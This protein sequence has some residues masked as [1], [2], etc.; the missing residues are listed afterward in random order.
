MRRLII[1]QI[2][3]IL[4]TASAIAVEWDFRTPPSAEWRE[5]VNSDWR[6]Y[7]DLELTL[8]LSE[9]DTNKYML[10]SFFFQTKQDQWFQN[11]TPLLLDGTVQRFR[12]RL[13]GLSPDWRC[14]NGRRPFDR[15]VLRWVRC[16]GVK[17]FSPEE[18]SGMITMNR[19]HF[20]PRSNATPYFY[21]IELPV[22]SSTGRLSRVRFRICG[23]DLNPFD[24]DQ[25][26]GVLISST[27]NGEQAIPVYY[28][29]EYITI[30]HP[31][32]GET[33]MQPLE[34]PF[35]E[36]NWLPVTT[37]EC[38]LAVSMM[39]LGKKYER[40]IGRVQVNDKTLTEQCE[41]GLVFPEGESFDA[42]GDDSVLL[43]YDSG[44]W[45][46]PP[47][48]VVNGKY[49]AVPLDWTGKWGHYFGLG[50]FDQMIAWKFEQALCCYTGKPMPILFFG[51]DELDNMG[52]FNWIDHP[53]NKA[54]GGN[55]DRP[56]D[57]FGDDLA[58]ALVLDRARYLW[59]RYGHYAGVSGL[60][61]LTKRSEQP[62]VEWIRHVALT[63]SDELPDV[64]IV[65]NNRDVADR[66]ESLALG[67]YNDWT[68]DERLSI[69]TDLQ[70]DA[71][72]KELLL[73]ARRTGTAA[74]T[75]KGIRHWQ[76]ANA[77][78][79]DIHSA[80]SPDYTVKVLCAIRTDP[81]SVFESELK[82]LR[83][84]EWTRVTFDLDKSNLWRCVGDGKRQMEQYDLLNIREVALRFFG[85]NGSDINLRIKDPI[86][87]WPYEID[88]AARPRFAISDIKSNAKNVHCYEKFEL[89]F[90]LN[91]MFRNPYDPNEID[92]MIEIKDPNGGIM[93]H[94]G[95][96]HEPWEIK[97][98]QD[99]EVADRSGLPGWRVRCAPKRI[100]RHSWT[101]LAV[102][103]LETASVSGEFTCI[104]PR[105]P[106]F[107]MVSKSDPRF[108]EF[109][110]GDYYYPI[111]HNIRSPSDMRPGIYQDDVLENA[112]WADRLGIMAYAKWFK[113]M[114][115]HGENFS[116]IWITPW[117]CGLEWNENHT[118]YYGLGYYN[119]ANAARLDTIL[120]LAEKENIYINLETMHH[121]ALS[122]H[123][124]SDWKHNP[125][126]KTTQ[127]NGLIRYA[128]DFIYDQQSQ[129]IHRM[130]LRYAVARWGYSRAIA[131]WGVMTE[132]EWVEPYYRSLGRLTGKNIPQVDWVPF[133]YSASEHKQPF[134]EWLSRTADYIKSTDSHEHLV[135]V[136]FSNPE[137]GTEV[138]GGANLDIVHNNTYTEFVSWWG[139]G[140]LAS[141]DG[142][143][144]V[145]L[146]FSDIYDRY[147]KDKPLMVG[148]WGGSPLKNDQMHLVAELHTGIWAMSM[149]RIAGIGGYWWWNLVD[150]KS[151]YSHFSA[152]ANFL[153]GEDRRGKHYKSAYAKIEFPLSATK[154]LKSERLGLVLYN[155]NTLF[156]YL[157]N[158]A[159][160]HRN[161]SIVATG[162]NDPS[163]P[164][165][166]V[167]G[168][169]IPEIMLNGA[170]TVEYWDTFAGKIIGSSK[171]SL[172]DTQRKIPIIS[173]RVDLAL[174]MKPAA[175]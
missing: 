9:G 149:T 157:C 44:G 118:G 16:W 64:R 110:N 26:S 47:D 101:V 148:E 111:G 112:S 7:E 117:W 72:T 15:D 123:I 165:S 63:L 155:R 121:G 28:R 13:D 109:S 20:S 17:I 43:E 29:Q 21:D 170:Y 74:I 145:M 133:D 45:R 154:D 11:R 144:D 104:A 119:Q 124:D 32:T 173:Y 23:L 25:V 49:W 65:S 92:V 125:L 70:I 66:S 60:A 120:E 161:R 160:N 86:L 159:I 82:A 152:L 137:H 2:V 168:L 56:T 5:T 91:R 80:M 102:H 68:T 88:I 135:T 172:S 76:S 130:K 122:T 62:V 22:E 93:R 71:A 150:A 87:H 94:P 55:I 8:R 77:V 138:W 31:G 90:Q 132:A 158:K 97:L 67:M 48:R 163:F 162:F 134:N 146:A 58:N 156:A 143:A 128:T 106:G 27:A 34:R 51:E 75:A 95:Y 151:L 12:L 40:S 108:F 3:L 131:W 164:E 54:N 83:D 50:E 84:G 126:S 100:G 167:G 73:K 78:S 81:R 61:I 10:C 115:Q 113:T 166:G 14:G 57:I 171:V 52:K 41:M 35:W 174:K 30:T 116:R 37:G 18:T 4:L 142:V 42:I 127:R 53:L 85:E 38:R 46:Y 89:D 96:Y 1:L 79:F 114:K 59:S 98:A 169:E 147:S 136:H 153:N 129:Q 39:M 107:V 69:R 103:G 141:S 6:Q 139:A 175:K 36:A 19:L 105:T 99:G 24:T 33:I 140:R